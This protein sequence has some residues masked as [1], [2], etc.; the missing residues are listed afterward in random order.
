MSAPAWGRETADFVSLSAHSCARCDAPLIRT[1]R[2]W[3]DDLV[4]RFVPVQRYRCARYSCQW[5][6][7]LRGD[8]SGN[9]RGADA[10]AGSPVA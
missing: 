4:N 9:G 2:R 8:A 1:P 3:F 7:N 5:V 6:G 10:G